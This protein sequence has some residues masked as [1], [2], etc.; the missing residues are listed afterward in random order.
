MRVFS[1][2]TASVCIF[3]KLNKRTLL[4]FNFSI[5]IPV[6]NRPEELDDLLQSI[7]LQRYHNDF[8]VVVI[9]DGSSVPCGEII[10][11]YKDKLNLVYHYK[12]NTG[13]GD[14]RNYGM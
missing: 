9:D 4:N 3:K 12:E 14:S 7:V 6:Y 1:F 8:E 10:E 11:K 5:I 13:P 2:Y